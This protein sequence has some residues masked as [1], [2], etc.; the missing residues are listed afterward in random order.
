MDAVNDFVIAGASLE[1][2]RQRVRVQRCWA[3]GVAQGGA[4][5]AASVAATAHA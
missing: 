5:G 3:D 1:D 2:H 4:L